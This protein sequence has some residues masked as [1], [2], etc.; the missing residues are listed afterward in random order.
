MSSRAA[1]A[2]D[3]GVVVAGAVDW[4]L[5]EVAVWCW[6]SQARCGGGGGVA[7]AVAVL[8]KAM[9]HA[10]PQGSLDLSPSPESGTT[11]TAHRI[12]RTPGPT[13]RLAADCSSALSSFSLSSCTVSLPAFAFFSS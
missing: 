4:R 12:Q 6:L 9:G 10:Q 13:G 8:V 7:V 1:A 11:E 5:V 2:A 3:A